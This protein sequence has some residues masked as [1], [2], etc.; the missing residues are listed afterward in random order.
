MELD[1]GHDHRDVSEWLGHADYATT[2]RAYAHWIP[3]TRENTTSAP[4]V[5]PPDRGVS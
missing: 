4:P 2:L 3:D 1:D 5:P